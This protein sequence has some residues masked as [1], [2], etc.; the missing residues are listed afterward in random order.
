TP[1]TR[2]FLGSLTKEFTALA[3]LQLQ[4]QGKLRIENSICNYVTSCPPQ[5]Q[6]ITIK[7]LL[8]H[9]SGI[10]APTTSQLSN[11]SPD[12][13]I[14]SFANPPLQFTP[15]QM[16]SYCSVCY[17]ILGYIVQNVS[18]QP[19]SQFIQ[20]MILDPLQMTSSGFDV[21]TYYADPNHAD[22]YETWG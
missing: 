16:Y 7:E 17:Q 10:Q 3:I 12:A 4:Q 8:T 15:G 13:W 6:A 21:G 11:A 9:T 18:G 14:A 20:Q 1:D 5:W 2:F 19:Y 22:G